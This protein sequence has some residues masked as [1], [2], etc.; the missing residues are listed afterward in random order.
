MTH[1]AVFY[2]AAA[3]TVIA[4]ILHLLIIP[5]FY[6]K[7]TMDV[8]IFFMIS[9]IA[10]IFWAVPL[11]RAWSNLWYYIGIGGTAILIVLWIIYVPG[12][13]YP[14]DLNQGLIEALQ[15]IFIILSVIIVMDR[16]KMKAQMKGSIR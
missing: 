10:Q 15:I 13:G 16:Q 1:K 7:M 8:I 9:G 3:S 2:V 14:V 12:A 5:M 6:A 11:I 4:G